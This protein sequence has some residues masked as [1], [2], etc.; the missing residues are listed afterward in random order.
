MLEEILKQLEKIEGLV[1]TT[2][3]DHNKIVEIKISE[4]ERVS[5]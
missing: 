1:I 5:S 2:L 3:Y 4:L